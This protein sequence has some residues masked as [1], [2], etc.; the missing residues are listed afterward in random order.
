MTDK[1]EDFYSVASLNIIFIPFLFFFCGLETSSSV[2]L[3]E[4][5]TALNGTMA[6]F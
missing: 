6:G 1:K 3:Q 4:L 5:N 2:D